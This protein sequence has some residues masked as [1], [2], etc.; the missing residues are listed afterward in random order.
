MSRSGLFHENKSYSV[1]QQ[2]L[3]YLLAILLPPVAVLIV[4]GCTQDFFMNILLTLFFYIPGSIHALVSVW[5][6]ITG[7]GESMREKVEREKRLEQGQWHARGVS[8][9]PDYSHYATDKTRP[10]VSGDRS[11]RHSRRYSQQPSAS[12]PLSSSSAKI[13]LP[14][15][16]YGGLGS[17]RTGIIPPENSS[18]SSLALSGSSTITPAQSDSED[19]QQQRARTAPMQTFSSSSSSTRHY[20]SSTSSASSTP[21]SAQ[22]AQISGD[23]VGSGLSPMGLDP[24]LEY[25]I[26]DDDPIKPQIPSSVVAVPSRASYTPN[27]IAQQQLKKSLRQSQQGLPPYHNQR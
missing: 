14:M 22:I 27:R 25:D 26:D 21:T 15:S 5:Q 17:G 3:L 10:M 20:Q 12:R 19:S 16:A 8:Y 11:H 1:F 2:T 4:H 24:I 7:K 9:H 23:V 18:S 6:V 13:T